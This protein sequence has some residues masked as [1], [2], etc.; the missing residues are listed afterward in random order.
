MESYT[1]IFMRTQL[2]CIEPKENYH[3][4]FKKIEYYQ[5]MTLKQ[6]VFM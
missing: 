4:M 5:A 2:I 3:T 6:I 1:I